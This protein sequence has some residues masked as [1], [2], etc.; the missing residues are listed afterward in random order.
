LGISPTSKTI[1]DLTFW[2][3]ELMYE[4]A[5]SYPIESLRHY[6][7]QNKKNT[8]TADDTDL[9]ALGYTPEQIAE[10]KDRG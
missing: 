8:V 9:L 5:M 4:T 1:A 3:I 10:M 7:F 6:Y 2:Q